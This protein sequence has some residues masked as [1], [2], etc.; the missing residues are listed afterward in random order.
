MKDL[1]LVAVV[2]FVAST[3]GFGQARS[4][5]P[6]AKP[7][8]KS[9]A[10]VR[11]KFDPLRIPREDLDKAIDLASKSG[12]RIILDVGGEWCG[13][14]VH[15]DRF[16]FRYP[17]LTRLR[18]ANFVWVKVNYSEENENRDFLATYPAI[19]G[20]PHLF[21]LDETGKLIHS[22]NTADLEFGESYNLAKF[23]KFLT[24][25]SPKRK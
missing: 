25:W 3:L 21:V 9:N 10:F 6:R 14:C 8:S 5:T 1:L 13:W 16:F 4:K 24:T 22:Q 12:K 11:E 17:G 23:T 15:M 20:Y 2:I 19:I 18:D 7:V